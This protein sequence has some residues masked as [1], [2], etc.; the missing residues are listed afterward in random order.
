MLKWHGLSFPY[1]IYKIGVFTRAKLELNEP[2]PKPDGKQK[3]QAVPF[4][5][6]FLD[7]HVVHYII[8]SN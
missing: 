2:G 5:N 1:S 6:W 8:S 3:F 4:G 7:F